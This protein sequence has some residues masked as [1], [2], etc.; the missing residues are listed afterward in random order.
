[1]PPKKIERVSKLAALSLWGIRNYLKDLLYGTTS[2]GVI[3]YA[4]DIEA[5]LKAIDEEVKPPKKS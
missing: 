5:L 2:D 4:Q 1:M 3:F